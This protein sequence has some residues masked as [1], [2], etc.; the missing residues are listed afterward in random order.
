MSGFVNSSQGPTFFGTGLNDFRDLLT[1]SQGPKI[2]G[3][4]LNDFC[5]AL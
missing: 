3:T 1:Q 5:Q 2:Y 4:G